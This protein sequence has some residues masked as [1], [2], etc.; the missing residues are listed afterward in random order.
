MST[1][2]REKGIT[3][4]TD[5]K[6]YVQKY[7]TEGFLAVDQNGIKIYVLKIKK[8]GQTVSCKDKKR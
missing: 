1:L 5:A 2:I 4:S 6:D 3:L 7:N 8:A